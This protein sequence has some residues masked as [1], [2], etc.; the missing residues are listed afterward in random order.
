MPGDDL[1]KWV[2]R[3]SA[4]CGIWQGVH[5]KAWTIYRFLTRWPLGNFNDCLIRYLIFQIISVIDGWGIYYELALRWMSLDL[6]DDKSTLVQVMAWCRQATNHYLSQCWPRSMSPYGVTR[7]QWVNS[8][9][10]VV[11]YMAKSVTYSVYFI[12]S[13]SSSIQVMANSMASLGHK[14]LT[15]CGLVM[16]YGNRDL[17]QHWQW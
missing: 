17:D 3:P 8:T 11:L 13:K 10:S 7:P 1:V 6:T 12:T 9:F 15:H 2:G 5:I 16:P 4:A 14:D